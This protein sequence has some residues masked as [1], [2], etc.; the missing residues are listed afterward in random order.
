M[1]KGA[2]HTPYFMTIFLNFAKVYSD[3][4]TPNWGLLAPHLSLVI[5]AIN[6]G[7][8]SLPYMGFASPLRA[9]NL[10]IVSGL[11]DLPQKGLFSPENLSLRPC[12]VVSEC[13]LPVLRADRCNLVSAP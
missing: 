2:S 3:F 13:F 5:H 4:T 6:S 1:A 10:A 11:W 7:D 9:C 12:I 8:F